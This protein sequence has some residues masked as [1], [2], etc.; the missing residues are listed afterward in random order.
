LIIRR[1]VRETA[2]KLE[3][4]QATARFK[5]IEREVQRA[6]GAGDYDRALALGREKVRL[7]RLL[8]EAARET[9]DLTN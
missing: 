2:H 4:V 8:Q 6:E 1:V 9:K 3:R 5:E 7:H